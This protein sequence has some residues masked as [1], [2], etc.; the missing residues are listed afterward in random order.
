[1]NKLLPSLMMGLALSTTVMANDKEPELQRLLDE[2]RTPIHFVQRNSMVP[3]ISYPT[4]RRGAYTPPP[5]PPQPQHWSDFAGSFA[6]T[7][8]TVTN[9]D[10]NLLSIIP[11]VLQQ[12]EVNGL[13][14]ASVYGTSATRQT[15]Y[16]AQLEYISTF[17]SLSATNSSL[18]CGSYSLFQQTS[19]NIF[20]TGNLPY[21]GPSV[22]SYLMPFLAFL[23]ARAQIQDPVELT[24]WQKLCGWS[25]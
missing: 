18:V 10:Q 15:I 1:M 16:L 7:F 22:S 20:I 12:M 14:N 4:N 6:S 13:A 11:E 19:G 9:Y 23:A 8:N 17:T 2:P 24:W 25:E 5:I 21:S 3:D